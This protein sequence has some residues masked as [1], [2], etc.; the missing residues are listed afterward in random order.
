MTVDEIIRELADRAVDDGAFEHDVIAA[1]K[2]LRVL[3]D[4]LV[5]LRPRI[6]RLT[7]VAGLPDGVWKELC[8]IDS[9]LAALLAL[10]PKAG[11]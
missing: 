7:L 6:G 10:A 5:K 11:T 1:I 8:L 9:D 2:G 4:G 3:H